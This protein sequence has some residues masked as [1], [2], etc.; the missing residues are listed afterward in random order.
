MTEH[1]IIVSGLSYDRIGFAAE[2][3]RGVPDTTATAYL[4]LGGNLTKLTFDFKPKKDDVRVEHNPRVVD[5]YL[6]QY[7]TVTGSIE[8]ELIKDSGTTYFSLFD[9]ALLDGKSSF[10]RKSP[11]MRTFTIWA[12]EYNQYSSGISGYLFK[13]YILNGVAIESYKLN[14]K[15]DGSVF[16][17]ATFK[18]IGISVYDENGDIEFGVGSSTLSAWIGTPTQPSNDW[19][20]GQSYSLFDDSGN[21]VL[22]VNGSSVSAELK[23]FELSIDN[24]LREISG[25]GTKFKKD[26]I[27]TTQNIKS[28]MELFMTKETVEAHLALLKEDVTDPASGAMSFALTVAHGANVITYSGDIVDKSPISREVNP[29]NENEEIVK[30]DCV[31]F[32]LAQAITGE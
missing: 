14:V 31:V 30:L 10:Y 21:F 23:T 26:I 8:Y 19:T 22:T 25:F 9:Y 12:R 15:D 11:N 13:D 28:T 17:T 27:G 18:A 6:R 29:T 3:T 20:E 32:N 5:T 24:T 1:S 16:V 7:E 4:G 2:Q